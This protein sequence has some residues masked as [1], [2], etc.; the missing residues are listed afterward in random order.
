ME[1]NADKKQDII[2]TAVVNS[3]VTS[4]KRIKSTLAQWRTKKTPRKSQEEEE[5]DSKD[6]LSGCERKEEEERST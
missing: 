6:A 5:E 2:V 3:I 4:S 1:W